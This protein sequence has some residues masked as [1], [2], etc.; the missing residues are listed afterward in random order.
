MSRSTS[1]DIEA[2][3]LGLDRKTLREL[4]RLLKRDKITMAEFMRRGVQA[5]DFIYPGPGYRPNGPRAN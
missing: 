2:H 5:Y 1:R 3:I 4:R